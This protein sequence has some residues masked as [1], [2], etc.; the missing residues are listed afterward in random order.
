MITIQSRLHP[1]MVTK[2][3]N[4]IIITILIAL[5]L[6]Y[7]KPNEPKELSDLLFLSPFT[8][9]ITILRAIDPDG[10]IE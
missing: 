8:T 4:R 5:P 6:D 1:L 3:D 7:M 9:Y 2:H 10:K